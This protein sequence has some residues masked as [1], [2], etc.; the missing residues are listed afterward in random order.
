MPNE[1]ILVVEDNDLLREGLKILLETEGFRA[2]SAVHGREALSKM[3]SICPDLILSDISMPEMDGFEFYRHVRTRPEWVTIPFIF[4]TARGERDDVFAGKKLG[5]EDYLV[6]PVDRQELLTTIRS[7]LE[8]THQLLLAQLEQAYETS[9]IMLANAIELRDRYTRGHVER[10]MNIALIIA[11]RLGLPESSMKPL[12][13]GAIL[14]DIGK[15][16]IRETVLSKTGPLNAEEWTEMKKHTIYG[17]QLIEHISYLTPAIPIIRNHHER[18][19]GR[20]Y[21]DGLKGEEIPLGARIIAVA[22]S[23]DAMTAERVYQKAVSPQQ[24]LKEIEACSGTKY[25]PA[26]VAALCAAWGDIEDFL[27]NENKTS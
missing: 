3:D 25:D 15:I 9:L 22:D 13:F 19:D 23:F 16:Y 1:V 12:R 26:I 6:K 24:A 21:P 2:L 4:L 17:S 11:R 8:R 20:G 27:S 14:H 18:W 7:R 5:V 10:V